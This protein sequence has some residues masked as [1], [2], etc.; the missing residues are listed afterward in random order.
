MGGGH[1]CPRAPPL[2]RWPFRATISA[3][4]SQILYPLFAEGCSMVLYWKFA[5][6]TVAVCSIASTSLAAAELMD[7][8]WKIDGV[9]RKALIYAR[10]REN[11]VDPGVVLFHGHG[12]DPQ[13]DSNRYDFA[14]IWPEAM[15][16]YMKGLPT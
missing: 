4:Q 9:E 10:Q 15:A 11:R 12:K 6:L 7:R 14:R 2:I 1:C 3:L 5:R 13:H 16:V 8:E